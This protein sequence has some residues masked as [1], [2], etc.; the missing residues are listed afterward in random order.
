M[1]MQSSV[2]KMVKPPLTRLK[3]FAWKFFDIF[4]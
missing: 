2:K 3:A 4:S 1:Q